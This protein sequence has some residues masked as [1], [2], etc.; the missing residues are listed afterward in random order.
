MVA[1]SKVRCY[2]LGR[3]LFIIA[4]SRTAQC[5]QLIFRSSWEIA[6]KMAFRLSLITEQEHRSGRSLSAVRTHTREDR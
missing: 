1:K 2:D 6:M 4:V 5:Y 3:D